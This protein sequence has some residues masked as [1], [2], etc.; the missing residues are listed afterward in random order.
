MRTAELYKHFAPTDADFS[1]HAAIAMFAFESGRKCSGADRQWCRD[2]L[3]AMPTNGRPMNGYALGKHMMDVNVAMW[4]ND[5]DQRILF[6]F[7]LYE[8]GDYPSEWLDRVLG[9]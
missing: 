1:D 5:L 6:K 3:A 7:E 2:S 8:C 4:R 9:V